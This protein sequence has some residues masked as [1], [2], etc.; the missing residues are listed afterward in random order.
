MNFLKEHKESLYDLRKSNPLLDIPFSKFPAVVI[1]ADMLI[2]DTSNISYKTIFKKAEKNISA[3]GLHTLLVAKKCLKWTYKK[4][5]VYSPLF[6]NQVQ[7]TKEKGVKGFIYHTGADSFP[8][9][10]LDHLLFLEYGFDLSDEDFNQLILQ[11]DFEIIEGSWI[12]NFDYKKYKLVD[13]YEKISLENLSPVLNTLING[14]KQEQESN[15]EEIRNILPLDISQE[16]VLQGALTHKN[17]VLEGPP[18][19]GKSRTIASIIGQNLF[20]EKS[21]LFVAEKRSALTVVSNILNDLE[22]GHLTSVI[23]DSQQDKTRFINELKHSWETLLIDQNEPK[24]TIHSRHQLD[25]T[26]KKLNSNI[27]GSSLRYQELIDLLQNDSAPLINLDV[28]PSISFVED[29]MKNKI[30]IQ[31]AY[32]LIKNFSSGSFSETPI[33][34]LNQH[35]FLTPNLSDK[36][37]GY[38]ISFLRHIQKIEHLTCQQELSSLNNLVKVG[39]ISRLVQSNPS[40]SFKLLSKVSYRKEFKRKRKAYLLLKSEQNRLEPFI[41][42]WKTLWSIQEVEFALESLENTSLL[43]QKAKREIEQKFTL[44]FDQKNIEIPIRE[45]LKTTEEYW[46]VYHQIDLLET[47]LKADYSLDNIT[48]QLN[49]INEII[50]YFETSDSEL[51]SWFKSTKNIDT[52][53]KQL[54]NH[55]V[56]VQQIVYFNKLLFHNSREDNISSIEHQVKLIQLETKLPQIAEVLVPIAKH[57]LQ[58]TFQFI[59]NS[60]HDFVTLNKSILKTFYVN[61]SQSDAEFYKINESY[62]KEII[63]K[64]IDHENAFSKSNIQRI[65]FQAKLKFDHFNAILETPS[66]KLKGNQKELKKKLRKGKSILNKEF[67]KQRS[68]MAI[69]PLMESEAVEWIKVL[70][71]VLFMSPI[72]VSEIFPLEHTFDQLIF[73]EASQIPIED[74]IPCLQRA[75]QV[76]IA[77]DSQQMPPSSYFQSNNSEQYSLLEYC[78]YE[79]DNYQLKYHYRS[80]QQELIEFSNKHFYH[81]QLQAISAPNQNFEALQ[82]IQ[83]END[84]YLDGI[85]MDEANSIVSHLSDNIKLYSKKQ[86]GIFTLSEKQAVLISNLIEEALNLKLHFKRTKSF[87]R[88]LENLQG[89]EC[90]VAILSLTHGPNKEGKFSL[91]F[92]PIN[93][94]NGEKR[95]NVLFTRAKDQMITFA[96]FH[97]KY[98]ASSTNQGIL[99]LKSFLDYCTEKKELIPKESGQTGVILDPHKHFNS[100]SSLISFYNLHIIKGWKPKCL[101]SKSQL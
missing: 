24:N 51:L 74:C 16:V 87:I 80:N 84:S 99:T 10:L 75:K 88:S 37:D 15:K 96:S 26:L 7:S 8:N 45:V 48:I 92:G 21:C 18:G 28:N 83:L 58:D 82:F 4:E 2:Q 100:T 43:K 25:F 77:G 91:N 57:C 20:L 94:F 50:T 53:M 65:S 61:H 9:P 69:R 12:G 89:E 70:K 47:E 6:F 23:H 68:H 56:D 13:D 64:Q 55:Y 73:D 78:K 79:F 5:T 41:Q 22:I 27:V 101:L 66:A 39:S 29:W 49:L 17:I 34:H 36:L 30:I 86:I 1:D 40:L 59:I 31:Q 72:S 38:L 32:L 93:H 44:S 14:E 3:F 35:L 71:P 54:D 81:N 98:L 67:S 33:K 60:Q 46:D 95:L 11:N 97:P 19:T 76:I 42:Q 85:N 90:D 63:E 62:F 52:I